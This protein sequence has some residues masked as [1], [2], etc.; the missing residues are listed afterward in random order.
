M[1]ADHDRL[2]AL[3]SSGLAAALA[4][5][6]H[7]VRVWKQTQ[8]GSVTLASA[9]PV[10]LVARRY[11]LKTGV[12]CGVATGTLLA[13]LEGQ[14]VHP[15]QPF[16]DYPLAYGLLGLS[17]LTQIPALG[18]TLATVARYATHV[19]SGVLFFS[20]YAPAGRSPLVYSLVYNAFLIPDL[21]IALALMKVMESQAPHLLKARAP[22]SPPG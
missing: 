22:Q 20:S 9:L 21:A 15:L 13:I 10:F 17:A 3:V 8:G 19:A 16:I 12:A 6:L 7:F 4:V 14:F 2:E 18:A 1:E 11:G 5:M